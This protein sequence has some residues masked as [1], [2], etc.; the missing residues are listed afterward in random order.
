MRKIAHVSGGDPI[1]NPDGEPGMVYQ[2]LLPLK[3]IIIPQL[4]LEAEDWGEGFG[5]R[6]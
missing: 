4:S 1:L 2:W 5:C 6:W 3:R